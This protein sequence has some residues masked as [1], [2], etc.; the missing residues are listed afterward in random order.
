MLGPLST[1]L[2]ANRLSSQLPVFVSWRPD[3]LAVATDAFTQDWN[4]LPE[5][6]YATPPWGLIGRVLSQAHSQGVQELI[7]VAPVW[8][9][10]AWYPMLLQMLIRVALLIPQ[11]PDTIQAVCLNNLPDIIPRLAVWVI[12]GIN[13]KVATFLNQLQVLSSHHGETN[14]QSQ[15]LIWKMGLLVW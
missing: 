8:K 7:L 15:L 9:A 14:P 11:S 6:L 10:Q 13:V 4:T 3:P 2:F 1:D 5:K 12:S